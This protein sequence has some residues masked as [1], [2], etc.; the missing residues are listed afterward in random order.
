METDCWQRSSPSFRIPPLNGRLL[1]GNSQ[2]FCGKTEEKLRKGEN[3][4]D[5]EISFSFLLTDT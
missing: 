2:I 3:G 1:G 5:G 4:E